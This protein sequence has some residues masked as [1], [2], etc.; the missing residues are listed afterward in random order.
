MSPQTIA[1]SQIET[2][3]R[4]RPI[5]PLR[6]EAYAASIDAEGLAQPIRVRP[7]PGRAGVYILVTGGHRL[8]ALELLDWNELIVGQHVIVVDD[9][10]DA[11]AGL[12][13]VENLYSGMTALDRAIFLFEAKQRYDAKRG[14][15][16][17]RKRKDQ[18]SQFDKIMPET[19]II[20]SQRFSKHAAERVGLS[21]TQIRQ[22]VAIA[23]ALDPEIIPQL[24]GTM[25]ESNQNELKLLAELD[26]GNQRKVVAAIKGGEVKTI[27][28]ARVV[29]GLDKPKTDDPQTRIYADLLDRWS[30]ASN[31]TKRQFMADAGLVYTENE[32]A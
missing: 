2:S 29:V 20:F 14:E 9:S 18:Q 12:E 23:K 25:I 30:K 28:Q 13:L 11:A 6:A 21:D 4:K 1:L 26:G 5:D 31:K 27:S 10:E 17:G 16:R 19:G 24:R 7:A 3:G 15:A 32:K 22:S 8:A